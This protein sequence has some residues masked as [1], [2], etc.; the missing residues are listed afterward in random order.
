MGDERETVELGPGGGPGEVRRICV[1]DR[2]ELIDH[3]GRGAFGEVWS[4]RDRASGDEVAVKLIDRGRIAHPVRVRREI[5]ALRRLRVPGV[6]R[7]LDEGNDGPWTFIAM[8]LV[9]GTGFPGPGPVG[10]EEVLERTAALLEVLA[11]VHAQGVVHRDLK[12]ANVLVD[13]RGAV[14]ILDFGISLG[15]G[16]ARITA[17][18]DVVG[19]PA[20]LAPE[21]I[22]GEP[23][24][25][26]ADLYAVGVMLFEALT[27]ELPFA[28]E[29]PSAIYFERLFGEPRT[30]GSACPDA[31]PW[32]DRLVAQLLARSARRRPASAREV[33]ERL[34]APGALAPRADLPWLGRAAELAAAERALAE[35]RSVV[36]RGARGVG[37]SRFLRELGARLAAGGREALALSAAPGAFGPLRTLLSEPPP[38]AASL[39]EVRARCVAALTA[40]LARGA[41]VL[42]DDLDDVDGLTV[43]VLRRCA[44]LGGIVVVSRTRVGMDGAAEVE[45]EPLV[46]ADLEPLFNGPERIFHLVTD[47]AALL[48]ARTDGLPGAVATE[49]EAWRASGHAAWDGA[50]ISLDR[51]GLERITVTAG[52][53]AR[54]PA[55][56]RAGS[57]PPAMPR[58]TLPPALEGVLDAVLLTTQPIGPDLM[59]EALELSSWEV[60]AAL[61]ELDQRGWVTRVGGGYVAGAIAAGWEATSAERAQRRAQLHRRLASLM[62]IGDERR[63]HHFLGAHGEVPAFEA[64]GEFTRELLAVVAASAAAG[65]SERA[66]VLLEDGAATLR[67]CCELSEA[68]G[69]ALAVAPDLVRVL[70]AWVS[71]ALSERVPRAMDRVRHELTRAAGEPQWGSSTASLRALED[72]VSAAL[73]VPRAPSRAL[74]MADAVGPFAEAD[75]ELARQSVRV[76]AARAV[77][78]VTEADVV[79][80]A[81]RWCDEHGG[82]RA[83]AAALTWRAFEAYRAGRFVDAALHSERS[84]ALASD[85]VD[86]IAA[87]A[88]AAGSWLEAFHLDH[89]SRLARSAREAAAAARQP[90]FE[91]FATWIERTCAYRRE[92]PLPPDPEL[93]DEVALLSIPGLEAGVALTEAALALRAGDPAL[94]AALATR[95]RSRWRST[96]RPDFAN[97]AAAL[98]VHAGTAVELTEACEL[99][100]WAEACEVPGVGL[101]ALA[102]LR[103]AWPE[104]WTPSAARVGALS[105]HVAVEHW[106][107]RVDVLSVAEAREL[108]GIV[109]A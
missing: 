71:L 51:G 77:D 37:A 41:A 38:R 42:V 55:G 87:T 24:G 2:Y 93:I 78:A 54:G 108:I 50:R 10:I 61:E 96:Q 97:L 33:I 44:S 34:H 99:A 69:P 109:P 1:A 25:P 43:G 22:S 19:T 13:E 81:A 12:P 64:I 21:Q 70:T 36:V 100:R 80:S 103:P 83:R 74:L 66:R 67:R 28:A 62:P 79:D 9:R 107:T 89:A 94:C 8:D 84:A 17:A 31:P 20:Y 5:A 101:Q 58:P 6:V 16:E 57:D 88:Y 59:G 32:L 49:I 76:L 15:L 90:Y 73:T 47:G 86:A 53:V 4:A 98:A 72:L 30:L 39:E 3:L 104:G 65:R 105:R 14:T 106:S 60:E 56:Y 85:V 18:H 23:I 26:R 92:E 7:L 75:V 95:A 11:R 45:L 46:A 35:A 27:G 91:A 63:L 82:A 52:G 48:R 68:G 40:T 29:T 102:L